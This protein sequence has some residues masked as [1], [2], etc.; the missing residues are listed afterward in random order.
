MLNAVNATFE[1]QHVS[2]GQKDSEGQTKVC[3][4]NIFFSIENVKK[5]QI[6]E[7]QIVYSFGI[8]HFM[9]FHIKYRLNSQQ[10][11]DRK[12]PAMTFAFL[13]R[14]SLL[15]REG[16]APSLRFMGYQSIA[17]RDLGLAQSLPREKRAGKGPIK[18]LALHFSSV[19]WMQH[20]LRLPSLPLESGFYNRLLQVEP[21]K[22]L[23]MS[24]PD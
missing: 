15:L 3:K 19:C 11:S 13:G 8:M 12:T 4:V 5:D 7:S 10:V 9:H 2:T 1:I 20:A 23:K 14:G 17:L 16:Q 18:G 6:K 24:F 22:L 21:G